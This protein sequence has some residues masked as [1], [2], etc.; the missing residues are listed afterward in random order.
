M[1]PASRIRCIRYIQKTQNEPELR[2]RLGVDVRFDPCIAS[3]GKAGCIRQPHFN[4]REHP[5]NL[6][7]TTIK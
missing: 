6:T 3:V 1:G 2:H 4:S 7:S 5:A